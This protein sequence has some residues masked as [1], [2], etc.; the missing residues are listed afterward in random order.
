MK[1]GDAERAEM[2]RETE[3]QKELELEKLRS[4][5]GGVNTDAETKSSGETDTRAK[6]TKLPNIVDGKDNLDNWLKRLQ[7]FAEKSR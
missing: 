4:N 3:M 5:L 1:R 7:R 2:E 6:L